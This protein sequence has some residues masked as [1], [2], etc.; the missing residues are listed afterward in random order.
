MK[1]H[2]SLLGL[3][4]DIPGSRFF[5]HWHACYKQRQ[6]W[7]VR[8]HNSNGMIELQIWEINS[9][10]ACSNCGNHGFVI[11]QVCPFLCVQIQLPFRRFIPDSFR[12]LTKAAKIGN[13]HQHLISL[14]RDSVFSTDWVK[15]RYRI[16]P[17]LS[18]RLL[19]DRKQYD[20]NST[21]C[22]FIA[23]SWRKSKYV[24][25]LCQPL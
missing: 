19:D 15:S 23:G 10:L 14:S 24:S 2:V 9:S 25:F 17:W 22:L 12:H 16:T 8:C 21:F 3:N 13:G 5:A 11:L 20:V 18:M 4:R 1:T 6:A 7:D